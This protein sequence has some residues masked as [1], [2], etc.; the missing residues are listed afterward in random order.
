MRFSCVDEAGLQTGL[1]SAAVRI[2]IVQAALN[3]SETMAEPIHK[4]VL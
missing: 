1:K 2:Q 3:I 4:D